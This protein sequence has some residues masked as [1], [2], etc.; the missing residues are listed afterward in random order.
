MLPEGTSIGLI[1]VEVG[2][3][4][5]RGEAGEGKREEEGGTLR[6]SRMM[7]LRRGVNVV[8]TREPCIILY[9]FSSIFIIYSYFPLS[10]SITFPD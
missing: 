4:R 2:G 7:N 1:E 10:V 9:H 8:N 3:R 6:S 5:G